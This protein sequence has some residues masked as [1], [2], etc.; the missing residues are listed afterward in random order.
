M[1]RQE[2][3]RLVPGL[4]GLP[5]WPFAFPSAL[6]PPQSV[7]LSFSLSPYRR[8]VPRG[9]A[10]EPV[11]RSHPVSCRFRPYA[12]RV[13]RG[14]RV[15]RIRAIAQVSRFPVFSRTSARG[16]AVEKR[17]ACVTLRRDE[18]AARWRRLL[19]LLLP[20]LL[21]LQPP[22][23]VRSP[24]A[25]G[26]GRDGDVCAPIG[27]SFLRESSSSRVIASAIT[28]AFP[29]VSFTDFA[30]ERV[31]SEMEYNFAFLRIDERSK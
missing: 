15:T 3:W 25:I 9:Q 14:A 8:R 19:Q 16:K 20:M 26:G 29:T 6:C 1:L 7:V 21:M 28:R 24:G 5:G 10:D 22:L 27:E 2:Q 31:R 11:A 23:L 30:L 17:V 18:K 13:S 12:V 4:P